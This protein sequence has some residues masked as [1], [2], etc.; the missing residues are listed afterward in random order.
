MFMQIWSHIKVLYYYLLNIFKTITMFSYKPSFTYVSNEARYVP[1]MTFISLQNF[2]AKNN[3]GQDKYRFK[4]LTLNR[5]IHY[6]RDTLSKALQKVFNH[7]VQDD[8]K[9]QKPI[10]ILSTKSTRNKTKQVLMFY[11]LKTRRC[12]NIVCM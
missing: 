2:T 7:K 3:N 6:L 9:K 1:G 5:K 11:H 10:G 8:H 12:V 4:G